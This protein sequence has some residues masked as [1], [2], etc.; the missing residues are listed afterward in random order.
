MKELQRRKIREAIGREDY[1]TLSHFCLELLNARD[2]T[3][4][5]RRTSDIASASGEYVLVKFMASAYIL[6]NFYSLL[7]PEVREFLARDVVLCLE[8][9]AQVIDFLSR[10]EGSGDKP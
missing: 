4:G 2:W 1:K 8:K 7:S 10:Q 6:A 3:D 5:L 9:A